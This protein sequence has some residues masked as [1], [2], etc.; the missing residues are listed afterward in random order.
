MGQKIAFCSDAGA[1]GAWLSIISRVSKMPLDPAAGGY[2]TI[3]KEIEGG[4]WGRYAG[5]N[6]RIE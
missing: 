2:S 3:W 1:L 5:H 6:G 4:A